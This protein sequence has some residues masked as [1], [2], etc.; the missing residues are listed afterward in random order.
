MDAGLKVLK[1]M[2]KNLFTVSIFQKRYADGKIQVKTAYNKTIERTEVF[3]Y[4]FKAKAKSGKTFVFCQGG[5]QDSVVITPVTD[6]DVKNAPAL[7][8]GDTAIYSDGGGWIVCR[9]DGSVEI[10][11]NTKSFVTWE[12]LNTA[13]TSFLTA[14][15]AHTHNCTAP[16]TPS[17]PPLAPITLDVTAAKTEK[18]K[19]A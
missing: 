1:A 3:P 4:G 13:I 9:S 12:D 10:N 5:N 15:K 16:G 11:G 8:D 17:G 7:Q 18:V 2:I 6:S 19:T 14:L